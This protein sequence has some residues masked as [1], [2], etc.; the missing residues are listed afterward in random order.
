MKETTSDS[1]L[2]TVLLNKEWC[3]REELCDVVNCFERNFFVKRQKYVE[4][5]FHLTGMVSG[6]GYANYCVPVSRAETGPETRRFERSCLN[7]AA[8]GLYR[9]PGDMHLIYYKV[10]T[11]K[12]FKSYS[13]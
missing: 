11:A 3:V 12:L 4:F 7:I 9:Q 2:V 13:V 10:F 6:K 5:S 8:A 1:T